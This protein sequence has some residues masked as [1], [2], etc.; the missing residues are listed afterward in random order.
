MGFGRRKMGACAPK[1]HRSSR[2]FRILSHLD[3]H[4]TS[5]ELLKEIGSNVISCISIESHV[6]APS[7]CMC[8]THV[9]N[10]RSVVVSQCKFKVKTVSV[11]YILIRYSIG[12]V[13][14]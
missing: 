5:Q 6:H 2:S 3:L 14:L 4:L 8:I 1:T 13:S 10:S 12:L 11:V 7:L 9:V